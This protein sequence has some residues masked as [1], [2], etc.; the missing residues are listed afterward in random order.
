MRLE[1]IPLSMPETIYGHTSMPCGIKRLLV[2]LAVIAW[3]EEDFRNQSHNS[4]LVTFLAETT[5]CAL[6]ATSR[7]RNRDY[8]WVGTGCKYH[9]HGEET[10]CYKTMF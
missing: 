5:I 10:A 1:R 4:D 9:D 2:D 7:K 3:D 8:S 6:G